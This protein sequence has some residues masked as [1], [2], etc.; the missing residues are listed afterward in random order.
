MNIQSEV[1]TSGNALQCHI[2]SA[3]L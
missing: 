2:I 3:G 1:G